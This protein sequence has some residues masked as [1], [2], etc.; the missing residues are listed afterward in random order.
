MKRIY[1][2]DNIVMAGHI[3]N[4]LN[5]EGID[6]QLRNDSLSGALGEIP[7]LEC[8]PEVWISNDYAEEKAL[9]IINDV[10][11]ETASDVED[12]T[13]NCGEIIEGQFLSCW[14]CG[15]EK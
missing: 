11:R 5:S 7:T 3:K 2:S 1:S 13:C 15:E 10:T 14:N 9:K 6:C 12:W 8:W 4:L